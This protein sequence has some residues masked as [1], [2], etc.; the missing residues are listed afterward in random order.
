[1][2]DDCGYCERHC[3]CR[4]SARKRSREQLP[5][6]LAPTQLPHRPAAAEAG[7]RVSLQFNEAAEAEME[8]MMTYATTGDGEDKREPL[9]LG[10]PQ[11]EL[12]DWAHHLGLRPKSKA[13]S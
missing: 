1:M 3:P 13:R 10:S 9:P 2:H 4:Q 12:S 6:G 7:R 8:K 11:A 5:P